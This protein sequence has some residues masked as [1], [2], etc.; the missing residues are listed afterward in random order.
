ME[1]SGVC[2]AEGNA[3]WG[4]KEA[5]EGMTTLHR[6]G[7]LH[8]VVANIRRAQK[9]PF[10]TKIMV[11]VRPTRAPEMYIEIDGH[12]VGSL[13]DYQLAREIRRQ[14]HRAIKEARHDQR[15]TTD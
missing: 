2:V 13:A 6:K 5:A 4:K 9:N 11:P 10:G 8:E 7:F 14:I 1:A 3:Y 15:R 12:E